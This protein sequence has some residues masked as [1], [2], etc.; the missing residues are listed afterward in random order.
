MQ[1]VDAI[2]YELLSCDLLRILTF[3]DQAPL[4]AIRNI[5]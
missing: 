1:N 4:Y 5:G 3:L 2:L